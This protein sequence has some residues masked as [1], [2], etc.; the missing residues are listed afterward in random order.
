MKNYVSKCHNIKQW[1]MALTIIIKE[2][3]WQREWFRGMLG[4]RQGTLNQRAMVAMCGHGH[5]RPHLAPGRSVLLWVG[6]AVCVFFSQR[7]STLQHLVM[8]INMWLVVKWVTMFQIT[9]WKGADIL[10]HM[11]TPVLKSQ[12]PAHMRMSWVVIIDYID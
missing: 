4:T 5:G 9:C 7:W 6:F 3:W 8:N 10:A 11:R 12:L 1:S 2:R